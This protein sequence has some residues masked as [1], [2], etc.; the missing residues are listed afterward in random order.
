MRPH[1]R[2]RAPCAATPVRSPASRSPRTAKPWPPAARTDV[3]LWDIA[4]KVQKESLKGH[5][6]GVTSVAF[7]PDGSTLASG[8]EDGSVRLW[9]PSTGA[10]RKKFP[11]PPAR[12]RGGVQPGRH[13]ARRGQG[14]R[15]RERPRG[16]H[17]QGRALDEGPERPRP[18]GSATPSTTVQSSSLD[19]ADASCCRSSRPRLRRPPAPSAWRPARVGRSWS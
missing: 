1:A 12:S 11:G 18:R 14:E 6:G 17:G 5:R 3:K 4:A 13:R 16:R 8:G 19:G 2:C 9:D 15:R 7:S 10:E